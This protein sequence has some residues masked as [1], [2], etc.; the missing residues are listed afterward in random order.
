MIRSIGQR[1]GLSALQVREEIRRFIRLNPCFV[2]AG[3]LASAIWILG[4]P[5]RPE[6]SVDIT[7]TVAATGWLRQPVERRR[8]GLRLLVTPVRVVQS[9][10]EVDYDHPIE[11]IVGGRIDPGI[12]D[13]LHVGRLIRFRAAL[14]TPHHFRTPGVTDY[15]L[16]LQAQGILHRTRLKSMHQLELGGIHPPLTWMAPIYRYVKDFESFCRAAMPDGEWRTVLGV[17]LGRR[18]AWDEQERA[19]L[20]R[21]GIMHLFVVS[22]FHVSLLVL[23][24]HRLLRRLRSLAPLPVLAGMWMYVAVSGLG[25]AALRA[26]V[27]ASIV[28]LLA[29][30]GLGSRLLNALG[31]AALAILCFDPQA[32]FRLGFQFSFLALIAIAAFYSPISGSLAQALQGFRDFRDSRVRVEREQGARWRRKVRFW[33]EQQLYFLPPEWIRPALRGVSRILR[34]ILPL[35]CCSLAIQAATLPLLLSY[36]NIWI[37]TQVL[38]N[39]LLAPL[40][41]LLTPAGLL[42]LAA[43]ST[44]AGP[45]L[46]LAVRSFVRLCWTAIESVDR[47]SLADFQPH[48]RAG[49]ALLYAL[50]LIGACLL[51]S[52]LARLS[53]CILAP[54]LLRIL[55]ALG[56]EE[57]RLLRITMLDVGQGESLHIA[58][59]GGGHALVDTGGAIPAAEGTQDFIGRRVTARYLWHLRIARLG[60]VLLTHPHADHVAGFPFIRRNFRVDRTY[61][62]LPMLHWSSRG[63]SKLAEPARFAYQGVQHRILHPPDEPADRRNANDL[64]LVLLLRYG[65]FSML[66]TGD[67]ESG[68]ERR[69]LS[70]V[71]PVTVLKV[72]HHGSRSSSTTEFLSQARPRVALISAGRRS[73]FGHPAAQTL[74][75]LESLGIEWKSTARHGSLRVISDGR[76]WKLYSFSS[77]ARGF[78]QIDGGTL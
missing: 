66:L 32:A 1:I 43:Y 24:L 9:G 65:E 18:A 22:G 63:W 78:V 64:S 19:L 42:L 4:Q 10:R 28:Y 31:L 40:I 8:H 77:Q 30:L 69:L 62:F 47:L 72:A 61:A 76:F 35:A 14:Q 67:I 44:P 54:L 48:P 26:G 17:S 38:S 33:A 51:L 7:R 74:Q 39:L 49:E 45:W 20:E 59:P 5:A 36:S 12:L 58:Y 46:A 29:S 41:A 21:L 71:R 25:V 11:V 73:P 70:Q 68:V 3:L 34:L 75:R 15:R 27:M 57:S 23:V 16:V 50:L 2:A 56:G 13:R 6:P 53:A 52:G 37:W 60:F 55:L